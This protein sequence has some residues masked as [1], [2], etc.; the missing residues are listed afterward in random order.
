MK[1]IKVLVLTGAM[2]VGG[3][4]NQL[5]H[6]LRNADKDKFQI[7]FTSTMPCGWRWPAVPMGCSIWYVI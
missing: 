1:K 5:M 4:E 3:I 6:L 7:D 2:D